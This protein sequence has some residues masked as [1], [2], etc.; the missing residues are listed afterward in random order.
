[1]DA[2]K[3]KRFSRRDILKGLSTIPVLGFFSERVYS[4]YYSEK[5]LSQGR[6]PDLGVSSSADSIIPAANIV[7]GGDKIRV[8]I[9]GNGMRGPQVLRAMGFA[10]KEWSDSQMKDG[11]PNANLQNFLHQDN[12]DIEITG[13]CDTFSVRANR[14]A[15]IAATTVRSGGAPQQRNPK[16]YPTYRDM[17][18]DDNLDA[19]VIMTPDHWHA[20]MAM[21]AARAGKHIYL[22]KPMCQTAEEAKMLRQVIRETGVVLQVGHQNRQQASYIKAKEIIDKGILG[23]ISAIETYTNRNNDHGAWIRGIPE[24][25][26]AS[27][28]NWKEFLGDKEPRS[29]D[30]DRYFNWQKWFEYGTGPAGNQFTHEFDCVNQVMG[31][32]IPQKV[33]AVGGNFYFKDPRDIP[34][35]LNC[36]FEYPDKNLILT[37]DCT[38]KSSKQR[39]KTFLGTDASMEVNVG[40]V[41]YPDSQSPRYKA[42][43]FGDGD[44]MFAYHPRTDMADA[45]TSATAKY[46]HDRGFGYTYHEGQR[47]DATYLHM[48]E[49][50]H[51]IRKGELPSCNADRGFE[52][53]VTFYMANVAYLENRI[54][55]WDA[56]KEVII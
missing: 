25:A 52:E 19:I 13:V 11:L 22:E 42:Y 55:E 32:G 50:L 39:D 29:L 14:A 9:V 43:K 12:F 34:D 8:G 30:L 15:A 41:V 1:M 47:V 44:P 28:V 51:C 31:L 35:V 56:E 3:T 16:I 23:E 38:L 45:I 10:E 54:V 5:S 40:T 49:W 53:T 17:L 7:S 4:R 21:D 26:S 33:S 24:G 6:L 18:Q 48:K 20:K 36:V 46:Y 2:R 27:N 37:Y